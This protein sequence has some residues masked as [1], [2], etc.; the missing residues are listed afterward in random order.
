MAK[1][2]KNFELNTGKYSPVQEKAVAAIEEVKTEQKR[3]E[4]FNFYLTPDNADFLRTVARAKGKTIN[5]YLGEIL[6]EYREQHAEAFTAA[7]AILETLE[8]L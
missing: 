5:G 7:K 6:E 1:K 4:R 3:T 8:K 2:A